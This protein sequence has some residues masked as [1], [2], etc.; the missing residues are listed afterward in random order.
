M[1]SDVQIANLALWSENNK[2][3]SSHN[4]QYFQNIHW[5][6][7]RPY[8]QDVTSQKPLLSLLQSTNSKRQYYLSQ[9][10][11]S[12]S[13]QTA[14]VSRLLF[15]CLKGFF[16]SIRLLSFDPSVWTPIFK[17]AFRNPKC[18][19]KTHLLDCSS[20]TNLHLH[21]HTKSL[22]KIESNLEWVKVC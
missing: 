18:T 7:I 17:R 16:N 4:Y 13:F 22:R 3:T 11:K 6:N 10:E 2:C 9:G 14:A 19:W 20:C 21:L 1:T 12:C 8:L 5:Q 15:F